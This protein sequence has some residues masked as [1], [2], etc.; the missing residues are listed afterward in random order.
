[1]E[2]I[3]TLRAKGS[4]QMANLNVQGIIRAWMAVNKSNKGV[5]VFDFVI[6]INVFVENVSVI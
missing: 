1:M 3:T 5:K 4:V 6:L 2:N